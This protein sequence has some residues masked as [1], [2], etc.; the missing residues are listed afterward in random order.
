M[1]KWAVK[2]SESFDQDVWNIYALDSQDSLLIETRNPE[3]ESLDYYSVSLSTLHI[4][5]LPI[6]NPPWFSQVVYVNSELLLIQEYDENLN[7]DKS[8]LTL[9]SVAK[10]S[11]LWRKADLRFEGRQENSFVCSDLEN[12]RVSVDIRQGSVI[13]T[14]PGETSNSGGIEIPV[15]YMEGTDYFN[16]IANYLNDQ[17]EITPVRAIDYLEGNDFIVF[18]YYTKGG[19]ELALHLIAM[20]GSGNIGLEEIL[21]KD[22]KGIADPPFLFYKQNLIFVKEKR[23]FFVYALPKE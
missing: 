8:S 11:I 1:G 22:L 19:R 10:G 23:H 4:T 7:P 20:N 13:A 2:F 6:D 3:T 17:R 14:K 5:H 15:H 21:G 9:F 18:S 12:N 16:E